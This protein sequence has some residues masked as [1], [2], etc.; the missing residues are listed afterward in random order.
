[1]RAQ[2]IWR[3][4]FRFKLDLE[5]SK[6]LKETLWLM[7]PK[8][9]QI[10]MWQI[11]LWWFIMLASNAEAGSV[12][13]YN[14][15]YNFQSVPVSLI[16]IAIALASYARLSHLSAHNDMKTFKAIVKSESIKILSLTGLAGI[17]LA[18]VAHPLVN[19]F[20]GGGKFSEPSVNLTALMLSV[21]A[22]SVPLESWMH[23]LSRAHY[24]LKNTLRPS[25]IHIAAIIFAMVLSYLLLPRIG[26]FA[27]PAAF[28]A[29]FA[30]QCLSLSF[31]LWNLLKGRDKAGISR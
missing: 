19:F 12:T 1:M 21:Y 31:S 23:L 30:L 8:M 20:L 9:A 18:M 14:F 26:L 5:F 29:G 24:S 16:G 28:S 13:I 7:L 10:G 4:G 25:L 27:L 2:A 3:Y 17:A 6:E 11:M 15:A 22:I